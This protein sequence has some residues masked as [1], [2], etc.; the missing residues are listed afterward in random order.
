ML[1]WGLMRTALMLA[2]KLPGITVKSEFSNTFPLNMSGVSITQ[3]RISFDDSLYHL[4]I[5][6]DQ[7]NRNT[8]HIAVF[9]T[10]YLFL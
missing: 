7:D 10:D 8:E 2:N 1:A 3:F 9:I 5:Q 4:Q 6:R